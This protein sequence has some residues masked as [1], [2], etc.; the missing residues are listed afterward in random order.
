MCFPSDGLNPQL[1]LLPP[2][3]KAGDLSLDH[4]GKRCMQPLIVYGLRA[5][6]SCRHEPLQAASRVQHFREVTFMPW[7][8]PWPPMSVGDFPGEFQTPCTVDLRKRLTRSPLG[9]LSVSL[10]ELRPLIMHYPTPLT[11]SKTQRMLSLVL[12]SCSALHARPIWHVAVM[13]QLIRKI[14]YSTMPLGEVASTHLMRTHRFRKLRNEVAHAHSW[15]IEPLSWDYGIPAD[16]SRGKIWIANVPIPIA[17]KRR[18][19]P[20]FCSPLATV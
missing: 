6:V 1:T 5:L 19:L 20:T 9:M 17:P 3:V 16:N 2:V 4:R 12:R 11:P 8:D 13:L 10:D 14:Y 15:K 18:L 7:T